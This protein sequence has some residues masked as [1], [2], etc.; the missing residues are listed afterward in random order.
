[1]VPQLPNQ[2]E[3][4]LNDALVETP[5]GRSIWVAL[6]GGLDSAL[7]L[8]LAA[9]VCRQANRPLRAIHI[10]HGLQAAADDFE[11]HC[12]VLCKQ[13]GVPLSVV[14]VTVDAAGGIEAAA[15]QAR[16]AAFHEHVPTGTPFGW[17]SIRMIKRKPFCWLHCGEAVFAG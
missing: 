11:Q 15:R 2:L 13:L 8:T 7:L 5:P 6:S 4:L 9:S 12:Q 14:R 17:P 16:Y 1:M 10:H 3:R